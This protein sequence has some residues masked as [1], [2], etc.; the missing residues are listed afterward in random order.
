MAAVSLAHH[1]LF[2]SS[3]GLTDINLYTCEEIVPIAHGDRSVV[4]WMRGTYR[5]FTNYEL[6]IVGLV[7]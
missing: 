3:A 1:S 5:S 7:E 2:R 4:L 6:E